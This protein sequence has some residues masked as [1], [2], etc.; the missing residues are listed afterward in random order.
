MRIWTRAYRPFI[1]GGDVHAPV[2]CDIEPLTANVDL[3]K[4]YK[5]AVFLA[6]SGKIFVAEMITG[7]IVGD[8]VK[9]VMAD[10]A[11]GDDEIIAQQIKD[12]LEI[13]KTAEPVTSVE[14]W[15]YLR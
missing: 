10:I 9:D 11:Q 15:H 6:P 8:S 7:G 4:G 13:G 12:N 3:G 5:G 14:F 1:L 2:C